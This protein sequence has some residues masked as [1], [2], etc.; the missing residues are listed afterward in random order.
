MLLPKTLSAYQQMT[1]YSMNVTLF[2][3]VIE[4]RCIRWF[5][6]VIA[7]V[8]IFFVPAPLADVGR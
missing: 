2:W 6:R 1:S 3:R 8:S 7:A 5:P 4:K